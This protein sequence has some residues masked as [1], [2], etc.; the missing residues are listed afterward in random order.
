MPPT[1][2]CPMS[3][4]NDYIID[5]NALKVEPIDLFTEDVDLLKQMHEA[6]PF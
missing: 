2:N 6:Y 5:S 4:K 3:I 1:Q